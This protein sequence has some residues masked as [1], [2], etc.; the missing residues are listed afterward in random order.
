MEVQALMSSQMTGVY[1][2][3]LLY[4]YSQEG[5]GYG[6]VTLS[7]NTV[8]EGPDFAK[9]ASVLSANAAP[10]GNGGFSATGSVMACPPKDPDWLVEDSSL[11]AF[12]DNAKQYL[13]SGAGQG[14][15]LKGPGS[16][17]SGSSAPAPDGTSGGGG[18]GGSGSGSKPNAAVTQYKGPDKAVF[19]ITGLAMLLSVIGSL[20]L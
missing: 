18:G 1:S 9:F 2:G 3:G 16:Q 7:G 10:S 4:E 13:T 17:N 19:L 14:P 15:G 5:N 6:I 11:P 20:L 8:T 12:P